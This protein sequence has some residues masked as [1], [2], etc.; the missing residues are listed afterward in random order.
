[1]TLKLKDC[2][3]YECDPADWREMSVCYVGDMGEGVP[4]VQ[5]CIDHGSRVTIR[6][7]DDDG[8]ETGSANILWRREPSWEDAAHAALVA[9]GWFSPWEVV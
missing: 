3:R 4:I 5:V 2:C 1:M 9:L 7:Y 6:S 8:N